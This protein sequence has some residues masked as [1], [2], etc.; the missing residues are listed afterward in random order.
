MKDLKTFI[1]K[2]ILKAQKDTKLPVFDIPEIIIE[3]PQNREFGDYS[4]NIAMQI[5]KLTK[6]D[7]HKV[8]GILTD[9]LRG[10]FL[11]EPLPPGFINF[12]IEKNELIDNLKDILK[13][14]DKY[15][16]KKDKRTMVIDYSAPNIAKPF[17][18]G[19]LRSTIIGQA[20]YNIYS[21]LGWKCVGDNHIGDWGTQFGKLIVAIKKWNDKDIKDLSVQDLEK[22]YINFHSEANKSLEDEAREWF[23]KLEDNDPEARSIWQA[24]VDISMK[25]FERV[26]KILGVKI[27]KTLGESFYEDKM[28]EVI[29]DAK[30]L[31]KKSQGATIIELDDVPLML[32]KSDG[33]T[34]YETR[35]LATI[36]YRH[37]TWKPDLIIWEVGADQD[38]HFRKVFKVAEML[39]YK[40]DTQYKHVAHGLFRWEDRKFST[41]KGDTIKLEDVISEAVKRAKDINKD[42]AEMVGIGAIKY[43]DLSRQP[44]RDIIFD[45]ERVVSLTGNSGPYIQYTAVRCKSILA[46]AKP[47]KVKKTELNAEEE[48]LLRDL[49]IFPEIVQLAADRFAPNVV[50][51]Y[52][53]DLCQNFNSF[54]EK[55]SILTGDKIDTRLAITQAVE[56]II[57]NS[58]TLLGIDIPEKM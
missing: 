1:K 55:H 29:E 15:G 32:L 11:V 51:N 10:D 42:V 8:A 23:K 45:L 56:Q 28:Q 47:F 5:A 39:N 48:L 58:L 2:A 46:K 53:F 22:L 38:L 18:I 40:G 27:D 7:P 14:K 6:I 4:T 3:T 37:K 57:N 54:Y 30:D 33:A 21:F 44:E 36:K 41:R 26:Y 9:Y 43:N 34:T 16:S 52:V 31:S 49:S 20:L 24:C 35:D 12:R 50:C 17:G 19:H 13:K 25:E